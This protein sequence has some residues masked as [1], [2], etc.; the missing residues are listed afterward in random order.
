MVLYDVIEFSVLLLPDL[1]EV[2]WSQTPRNG[3]HF[4]VF[5]VVERNVTFL[6][7]YLE[8]LLVAHYYFEFFSSIEEPI[9]A[10]FIEFVD[11]SQVCTA[12]DEP[13]VVFAH[14]SS[15][16]Q[17]PVVRHS[18]LIDLS[19]QVHLILFRLLLRYCQRPVYR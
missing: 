2:V 14:S 13:V 12:V 3:Q 10:Q 1:L 19:V 8:Q 4:V 18:C 6:P 7:H 15:T 16:H 5:S 9:S 11:D 17:Q